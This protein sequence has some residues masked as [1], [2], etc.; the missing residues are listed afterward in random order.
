M[1]NIYKYVD[2]FSP[3]SVWIMFQCHIVPWALDCSR[4]TGWHIFHSPR[5]P[6]CS[7]H[8]GP[9]QV[10]LRGHTEGLRGGTGET[11]QVHAVRMW[12]QLFLK[13]I[14]KFTDETLSM[15]W[16]PRALEKFLESRT[17]DINQALLHFRLVKKT[18]CQDLMRNKG[19]KY[20]TKVKLVLVGTLSVQGFDKYI[21]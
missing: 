8:T 18:L 5:L 11:A 6:L 3:V 1:G 4:V 7:V 16:H 9:V 10:C 2:I 20:L 13:I 17:R 15:P 19:Q 14:L 12:C 21:C